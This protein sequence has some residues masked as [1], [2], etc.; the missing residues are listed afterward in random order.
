M[1]P[2]LVIFSFALKNQDMYNP[3]KS[4][5]P[6]AKHSFLSNKTK[7]GDGVTGEVPTHQLII[8]TKTERRPS[9]RNVCKEDDN[10]QFDNAPHARKRA[11]DIKILLQILSSSLNPLT[12]ARGW[13]I[14][15][16]M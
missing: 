3:E 11:T 7:K 5:K 6:L 16:V 2:S 12:G 13:R 8:T 10:N 1:T 9:R 15:V 4:E 14:A